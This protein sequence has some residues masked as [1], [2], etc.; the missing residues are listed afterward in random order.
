MNYAINRRET[1]KKYKGLINRN[2]QTKNT[3]HQLRFIN[4]TS[5][6]TMIM[7]DKYTLSKNKQYSDI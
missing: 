6:I 3:Q 7:C 5:E 2:K 4:T 1:E